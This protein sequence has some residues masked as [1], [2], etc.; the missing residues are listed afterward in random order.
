MILS[1][2]G[3]RPSLSDHRLTHKIADGPGS[4]SGDSAGGQ[5][6]G[7]DAGSFFSG[8]ADTGTGLATSV[9]AGRVAG[10]GR[11]SFDGEA[12]G[13]DV[14]V[15]ERGVGDDG[16]GHVEYVL[17]DRGGATGDDG[18]PRAWTRADRVRGWI[19]WLARRP[20]E[21]PAGPGG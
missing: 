18:T 3:N 9:V 11:A 7:G 4:R 21:Q 20:G 13:G 8:G 16:G 14:V 15:A 1:S 17:A 5:N 6:P 10:P 12:G 2:Q 19:G